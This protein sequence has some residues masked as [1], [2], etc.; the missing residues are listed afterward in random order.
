MFFLNLN[1][2]SYISAKIEAG[3]F[4]F[5]AYIRFFVKILIETKVNISNELIFSDGYRRIKYIG[6]V[7]KF[8]VHL[9]CTRP[10]EVYISINFRKM[11]FIFD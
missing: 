5:S 11:K 6:L 7:A 3:C 2:K 4:D 8:G 1:E 10:N 9:F